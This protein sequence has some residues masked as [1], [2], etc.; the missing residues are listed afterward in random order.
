M[1]LFRRVA[2][3]SKPPLFGQRGMYEVCITTARNLWHKHPH[4]TWDEME[5]IARKASRAAL[6][7]DPATVK[8]V[9]DKVEASFTAQLQSKSRTGRGT[10]RERLDYFVSN[11]P[12]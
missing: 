2:P 11:W 10:E 5:H 1:G 8:N 3:Q 12:C 7:A 4:L 6:R 9:I